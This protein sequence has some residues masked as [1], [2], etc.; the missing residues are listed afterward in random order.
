[1]KIECIV[2]SVK[3]DVRELGIIAG[4]LCCITIVAFVLISN[5]VTITTSVNIN[6][7]L[8]LLAMLVVDVIIIDVSVSPLHQS[9]LKNKP[10]PIMYPMA[11]YILCMGACYIFWRTIAIPDIDYTLI[12]IVNTI[13]VIA[14]MVIYRSCV[15]CED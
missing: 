12:T 8:I 6:T 11:G 14:I 10:A 7:C 15:R 5:W 13:I 4:I 1:V 2:K 9:D 3:T